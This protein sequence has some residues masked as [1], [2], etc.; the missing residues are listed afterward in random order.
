MINLT[1]PFA[2]NTYTFTP[3]TAWNGEDEKSK[4]TDHMEQH[5]LWA[6]NKFTVEVCADFKWNHLNR[7]PQEQEDEK[8]DEKN[9]Q[10]NKQNYESKS[11]THQ[12][13]MGRTF[14]VSFL[15]KGKLK[16]CHSTK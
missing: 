14:M 13:Y 11:N 16:H 10:T 4:I 5:S 7:W 8:N 9:K 12:F 2:M 15:Y 6:I 3:K 1:Y